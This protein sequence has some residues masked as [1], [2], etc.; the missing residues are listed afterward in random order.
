MLAELNEAK[1]FLINKFGSL[2]K[3]KPGTYAVPT[4][5]SKGDAFMKVVITPEMGMK[6]FHLF[7]DE[8]LTL[9]WYEN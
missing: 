8:Q 5:T 2:E 3:V 9:S 6:D 7:K 4:H 1:K